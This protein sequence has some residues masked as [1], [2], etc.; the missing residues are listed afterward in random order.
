MVEKIFLIILGIILKILVDWL[1]SY[2]REKI[3]LR[4]LK[5]NQVE[6]DIEFI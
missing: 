2:I 6:I 3:R 5:K 1:V 4:R